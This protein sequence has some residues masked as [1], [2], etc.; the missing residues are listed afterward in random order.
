MKFETLSS[1]FEILIVTKF[2]HI[3]LSFKHNLDM[4][5]IRYN[6]YMLKISEI[7]KS[8]AEVKI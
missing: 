8:M 7:K 2:K 5:I 6:H 1:K 3:R 4:C